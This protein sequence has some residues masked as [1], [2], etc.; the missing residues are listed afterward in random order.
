MSALSCS[1]SRA[2]AVNTPADLRPRRARVLC[3]SHPAHTL[4]RHPRHSRELI[5]H[6]VS[7]ERPHR[8]SL[9]FPRLPSASG[10]QQ[11]AGHWSD[12]GGGA[13]PPQGPC[14]WVQIHLQ[15]TETHVWCPGSA[16]GASAARDLAEI[17]TAL[18]LAPQ[19]LG[20]LAEP[21]CFP[22]CADSVRWT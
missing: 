7:C 9:R 21:R 3:R 10:T 20:I 4:A 17:H 16:L 2:S 12:A 22:G 11:E 1:D 15:I 19:T 6:V 18:V 8:S 14:H 5:A 13:E